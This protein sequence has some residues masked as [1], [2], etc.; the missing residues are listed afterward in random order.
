MIVL[1]S[2]LKSLEIVLGGA[3]TTNQ[4]PW[5]VS[6]AEITDSNQS[7]NDIAENDG[8]TNNTTA[9]T[10]VAAP[11]SG[12]TRVVKSINVFNKDTTSATVTIQYNDNSTLRTIFSASLAVGDNLQYTSDD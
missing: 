7:V 8:A 10:M 6:Y 2:T 1:D 9:V 5:V 4:L 12:K 3:I 11:A